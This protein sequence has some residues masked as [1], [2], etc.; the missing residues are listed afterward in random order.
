MSCNDKE[1]LTGDQEAEGEAYQRA[2]K[3]QEG[4]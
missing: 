1:P 4:S 3:E 2:K